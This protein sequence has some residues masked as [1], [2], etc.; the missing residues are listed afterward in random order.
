MHNGSKCVLFLRYLT[1]IAIDKEPKENFP[2]LN[3]CTTNIVYIFSY[4]SKWCAVLGTVA[5]EFVI[6]P[7][8]KTK[9]TSILKRVGAASFMITFVSFS[10]LILELT[11]H[12]T[13]YLDGSTTVWTVHILFNS[14]TGLL[15]QLSITSILEFICAQSPYHM[16]GLLVSFAAPIFVLSTIIGTNVGYSLISHFCM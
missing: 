1:N 16:R 6:F 2:T 3:D 5:Y 9:L 15:F 4:Y 12:L 11:Q 13:S 10:C 14:T 8:F 7:I